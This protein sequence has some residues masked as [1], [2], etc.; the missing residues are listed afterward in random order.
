MRR[1]TLITT[2][3]TSSVLALSACGGAGESYSPDPDALQIYS[4]QHDN[5]T[6]AW[7]EGFEE[8]SGIATQIR[9]G[10]DASMG[11][12]I[13]EEGAESPA[14]VFLTENSPAMTLVEQNDLLA[15]VDDSTLELVPK[16]RRPSSGNWTSVAARSTVLVYNPDEI[17]ESELPESLMDLQKPEYQGMWGAGATQADFQAIVAGMLADQG[18]EKTA[19]WLEGLQENAEI[20]KH[21]V[22]TMNAVNAGEVPMGVIYHYYWYR[23][24]AETQ[25]GSGNTKLHYF[26]NGD[27]GAFVSLSAAGV[28]KNA[29]HPKKAQ[30][31]LAYI[32]SDEGQKVLETSG[33]K[34][35]SVAKGATS[36]PD[37]PTLE[38]LEAPAID[39]VDLDSEKVT[40]MMTDAGIL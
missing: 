13:V 20:Y 30:E 18:E 39:P 27:P 17:A 16:D 7:A 28:L 2:A 11:H 37:L 38:S 31:F 22:A 35:Y 34:E 4:S 25:E 15:P 40:Q 33:S 9:P 26:R 24:Q 23:D 3:L 1:R 12:M 36:D 8:Q 32:L 19:A 29:E 10:E 6:Q 21:N 14:D 5:L